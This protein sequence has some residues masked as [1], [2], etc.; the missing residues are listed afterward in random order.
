MCGL[1][2]LYFRLDCVSSW[3]SWLW[4]PSGPYLMVPW[5]PHM[6]QGSV[7]LWGDPIPPCETDPDQGFILICQC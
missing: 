7:C 3:P 6:A 2:H 4:S 5:W 1:I